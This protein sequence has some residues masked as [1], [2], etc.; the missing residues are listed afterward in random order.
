[1]RR[2]EQE[3]METITKDSSQTGQA[4]KRIESE[5][6]EGLRHGFFNITL[7]CKIANGKHRDFVVKAGKHHRY[8]ISEEE[9][10][11]A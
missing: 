1:M 8:L 4:L 6:L 3:L 9:A 10:K 11:K 2:K 7:E 5:V